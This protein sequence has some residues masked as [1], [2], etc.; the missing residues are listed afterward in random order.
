MENKINHMKQTASQLQK[1]ISFL[2]IGKSG[3][4]KS[5]WINKFI[6]FLAKRTYKQDRLV[7]ITQYFAQ[8]GSG[9]SLIKQE[10]NIEEFKHLQS[11]AGQN[12]G[13]AQTQKVAMYRVKTD[14]ISWTISDTPGLNESTLSD[15]KYM[16]EI[17]EHLLLL[18]KVNAIVYL[19]KSS[20]Y[21][22]GDQRLLEVVENYRKILPDKLLKTNFIICFT[23]CGSISETPL[24]IGFL[25]E[26]KFMTTDT[27]YFKF[28]NDGWCHPKLDS[29]PHS[30]DDDEIFMKERDYQN[31]WEDT[32]R[33]YQKFVD[34]IKLMDS[35]DTQ[36]IQDIFI[37]RREQ[38]IYLEYWEEYQTD[39]LKNLQRFKIATARVDK[40]SQLMNEL[41]PKEFAKTK[42]QLEC[43]D[44]GKMK[45]VS[46][47]VSMSGE[48]ERVIFCHFCND[49]C[50]EPFHKVNFRLMAIF[51]GGATSSTIS[52]TVSAVATETT[53]MGGAGVFGAGGAGLGATLTAAAAPIAIGVG[54]GA[55]GAT[56]ANGIIHEWSSC[57]TCKHR[58]GKHDIINYKI[59]CDLPHD[60]SSLILN[61][62]KCGSEHQNFLLHE[63]LRNLWS[64]LY[65]KSS[66]IRSEIES[67]LSLLNSF[68]TSRANI[69]SK[70]EQGGHESLMKSLGFE[71][72]D[73]G[74][75]PE[76]SAEISHKI[77]SHLKGISQRRDDF[78]KRHPWYSMSSK[79]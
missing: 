45:K 24:G 63:Y 70:L 15:S 41:K 42:Y 8:G 48:D 10:C 47:V 23:N 44:G 5:T 12:V 59:E 69:A 32:Q 53:V 76:L 17:T 72:K 52:G 7:A 26:A 11:D 33:Q 54:I 22:E 40:L 21:K 30:T 14:D 55:V 43:P 57:D 49:R 25:K 4:G 75:N 6:S 28:K 35:V 78:L 77:L 29:S 79:T 62:D 9:K 73:Y 36:Q 34:K 58:Y 38:E 71:L 56:A 20:D 66:K 31:S 51:G 3:D 18:T 27:P 61:E 46:K 60:L 50:T 16:K 65:S 1:E 37:S 2:V 74:Q 68:K 19:H 39:L 13:K 67:I 64:D